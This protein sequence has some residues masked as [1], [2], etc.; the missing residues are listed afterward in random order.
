MEWDAEN[1]C[2]D[3]LVSTT[4]GFV[5]ATQISNAL[6]SPRMMTVLD[7]ALG[8]SFA[9]I[10]DALLNQL[11]STGLN[12]LASTVN[13]GPEDDDW[14]YEGQNLGDSSSSFTSSAGGLNIQYPEHVVS[15]RTGENASR[16]IA[17]GTGRYSIKTP[18]TNASVATASFDTATGTILTIRGASNSGE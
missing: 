14:V 16:T 17:G 3:G 4:P 12:T 9:A 10:F 1:T 5:A 15:V 6:D 2:P 8:N 11:I 18:S 7:G 13:K